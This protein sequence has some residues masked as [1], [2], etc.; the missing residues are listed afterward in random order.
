MFSKSKIEQSAKPIILLRTSLFDTIAICWPVIALSVFVHSDIIFF[1]K[2]PL[3]LSYKIFYLFIL[4]NYCS[5]LIIK[6]VMCIEGWRGKCL[7]LT[8]ILSLKI[9]IY[10]QVRPLLMFFKNDGALLF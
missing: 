6:P 10:V 2:N 5:V 8:E 4:K 7:T 1:K 3:I 9:Y